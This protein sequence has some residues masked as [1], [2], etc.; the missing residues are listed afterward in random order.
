MLTLGTDQLH[1][2]TG[3]I[4]MLNAKDWAKDIQFN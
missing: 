1:Q 4:K 2:T 3:G